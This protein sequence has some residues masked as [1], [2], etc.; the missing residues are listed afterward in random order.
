MQ[1]Q[2]KHIPSR[3]TSYLNA[4]WTPHSSL[5]YFDPFLAAFM[6]PGPKQW[7]GSSFLESSLFKLP[8]SSFPPDDLCLNFVSAIF[9]RRERSSFFLCNW[10]IFSSR[11]SFFM[12]SLNSFSFRFFSLLI[13]GC[14]ACFT[15]TALRLSTCPPDD[16]KFSLDVSLSQSLSSGADYCKR[17]NFGTLS[18]IIEWN[19]IEIIWLHPT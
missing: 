10:L 6:Q 15:L 7:R 19:D 8:K 13:C 1:I 2:R 9:L 5:Q 16:W 14:F 12:R 18:C 17:N 11:L 4:S 3:Y